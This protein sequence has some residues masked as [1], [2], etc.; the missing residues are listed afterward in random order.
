MMRFTG[1]DGFVAGL[2]VRVGGVNRWCAVES[3]SFCLKAGE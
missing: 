1:V 3:V 2:C